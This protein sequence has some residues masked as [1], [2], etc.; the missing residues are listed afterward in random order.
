MIKY[1]GIIIYFLLKTSI[2]WVFSFEVEK[3]KRYKKT[4]VRNYV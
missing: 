1:L 4:S 3:E 2:F